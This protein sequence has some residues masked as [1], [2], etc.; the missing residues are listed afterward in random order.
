MDF[1]AKRVCTLLFDV[2]TSLSKTKATLCK[3]RVLYCLIMAN[4]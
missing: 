1:D 2:V 4:N 3:Q